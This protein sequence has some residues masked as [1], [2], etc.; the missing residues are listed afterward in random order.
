MVGTSAPIS[1]IELSGPLTQETA[2][3]RAQTLRERTQALSAGAAL[4]LDLQGVTSI[5]GC[6][7][8]LLISTRVW[9]VAH[10]VSFSLRAIP[11]EIRTS[12]SFQGATRSLDGPNP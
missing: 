2:V 5:D 11:H 8:Q 3:A 7:L 6:G 1:T 9:A 4:C 12:P 10:N